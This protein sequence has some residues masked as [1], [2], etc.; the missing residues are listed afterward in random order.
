MEPSPN[1]LSILEG[2]A[3]E[4]SKGC[5]TRTERLSRM[6]GELNLS[7]AVFTR[8][9]SLAYFFGVSGWKSSPAA[10]Y[11]R[12]DGYRVI[13]IGRSA[14]KEAYADE[15]IRFNDSPFETT[16]EERERLSLSVLGHHLK[17]A[18]VVGADVSSIANRTVV[19]MASQIAAMRR[20]KDA[21]EIAIIS[22]AIAANE[23]GY[24]AIVPAIRP[25]V[26]ELEI[27]S[28]FHAAA[29]V[30]SGEVQGE[31]GN[32]FRGGQPGGRPRSAPLVEGELIPVDAGATLAGYYSDMCRTFAVSG[33]RAFA[34]D[35][36]FARVMEALSAAEG[37]IRPGVR[38]GDVFNEISSFLNS[39]NPDWRF[40]HHLGHGIGLDPVERPFINAGSNDIL[41]EGCTFTLEPGLYGDELRGG[42]RLEQNYAI[43]DGQLRRL[44]NFRLDVQS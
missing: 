16:S 8:P 12:Q 25:G 34:Q 19:S 33:K 32:D 13:A 28:L 4:Q 44:S 6:L 5:R 11:I 17:D 3:G 2:L 15:T 27:Y 23:A 14:L 20:F 21:D 40:D 29:T 22:S 1:A 10:G 43:Q 41:E 39:Q 38:C 7:G 26:Q 42:I 31:L 30:A 24:R 36:A 9:Q 37:L 18:Q 35:L